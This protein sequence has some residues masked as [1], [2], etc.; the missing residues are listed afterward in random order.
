[1]ENTNCEKECAFVKSGFCSSDKE[2]PHY[3]ESWWE[4]QGKHEPKLVKDCFPKKFGM[5][6]NRLLYKFSC[7]HADVG[8]LKNRL[9]QIEIMLMNLINRS[10]EFLLE[11]SKENV[12]NKNLLESRGEI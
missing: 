10:N 6:Q 3:L 12:E 8:N 2:C 9:E 1:M 4:I 5:E 11:N 7:V